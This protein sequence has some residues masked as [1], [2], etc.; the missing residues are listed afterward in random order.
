MLM[1]ICLR[2]W[3][4]NL[5][6]FLEMAHR[7]LPNLC[8]STIILPKSSLSSLDFPVFI[9]CILYFLCSG[10][11][12]KYIFCVGNLVGKKSLTVLINHDHEKWKSHGL[13][14]SKESVEPLAPLIKRFKWVHLYIWAYMYICVTLCGLEKISNHFR[15]VHII[16]VLHIQ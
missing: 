2:I 11:S 13:V 16:L 7:Y 14:K 9:S 12:N 3:S 8:K 6:T 4:G 15:L 1:H 5:P 10:K